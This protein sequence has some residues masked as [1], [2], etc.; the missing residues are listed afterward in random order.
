[1]SDI[2]KLIGQIIEIER[3]SLKK[4][5]SAELNG[6]FNKSKNKIEDDT[7][8]EILNLLEQEVDKNDN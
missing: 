6:D 2:N 7:I 4:K 3:G 1:M 8:K 5:K